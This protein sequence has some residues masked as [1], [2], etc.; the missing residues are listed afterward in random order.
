M[1]PHLAC[2]WVRGAGGRDTGSRKLLVLLTGTSAPW[3]TPTALQGTRSQPCPLPISCRLSEPS[4][5]PSGDGSA[6]GHLTAAS[7]ETPAGDGPAELRTCRR[8][9]ERN[10]RC[11]KYVLCN[12]NQSGEEAFSQLG[13]CQVLA[14]SEV[15][16]ISTPFH[17]WDK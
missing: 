13:P 5:D 12:C 8:N 14:P 16:R 4:G 3:E 15:G 1:S 10:K 11:F 7:G 6:W 9:P 17:R 2:A